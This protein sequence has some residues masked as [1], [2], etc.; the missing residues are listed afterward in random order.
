MPKVII[1]ASGMATGG[2]ILHHLKHYA[3]DKRNTILLA[4]YQAEGTRG[5]RLARGE[6]EIKIHGKMV[7]IEAEVAK[8]DSMSAHADYMEILTWLRNFRHPPRKVFITHG[9]EKAAKAL[10]KHIEE[11]LGWHVV[12]PAPMQQEEF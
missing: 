3:G 6:K 5:D 7:R 10:K 9:E 2:R 8:L 4:G 1:S 12:I 11:E